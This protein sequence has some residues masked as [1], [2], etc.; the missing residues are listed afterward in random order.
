MRECCG[1]GMLR[2][3]ECCGSEDWSEHVLEKKLGV[4]GY[5]SYVAAFELVPPAG[6][7]SAC[8]VDTCP[9]PLSYLAF[10]E[11]VMLELYLNFV[12]IPTA[13]VRL[14]KVRSLRFFFNVESFPGRPMQNHESDFF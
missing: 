4:S 7:T 1:A 6:P 5:R 10:C 9:N 3:L 2:L 14:A 8:S 11:V 13:P 12:A